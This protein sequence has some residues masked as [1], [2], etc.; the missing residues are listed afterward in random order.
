M[1][2]ITLLALMC[3]TLMFSAH[4]A[5]NV[6]ERSGHVDLSALTPSEDAVP[7][8]EMELFGELLNQFIEAST[9]STLMNLAEVSKVDYLSMK[10]FDVESEGLGDFAGEVASFVKNLKSEGWAPL[11]NMAGEG[12]TL[13]ILYQQ[14]KEGV[15][16]GFYLVFMKDGSK[17][18]KFIQVN[19]LGVFD[20]QRLGELVKEI[21]K[22]EL[23][24]LMEMYN[25]DEKEEQR[26]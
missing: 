15:V 10:M 18:S 21:Q 13:H 17:S 26:I 3:A 7:T 25:S 16:D 23:D 24:S 22:M 4:A 1:K 11:F 20:L 12:N 14:E 5:D 19:L 9:D 2:K 6:S 8:M